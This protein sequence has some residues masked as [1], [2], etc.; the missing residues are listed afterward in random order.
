MLLGRK[1]STTARI[2]LLLFSVA[3]WLA[4]FSVV[5]TSGSWRVFAYVGPGLALLMVLLDRNLPA[6]LRPSLRGALFG[7]AIGVAMVLGT[8][9]GYWALSRTFPTIAESTVALF[10]L[11]NVPGFSA[12]HRALLIILIATSEELIFRGP[13]LGLAQDTSGRESPPWTT[14]LA[15][16]TGS[17]V[18]Y[19]LATITL[20]SPL[21]V[22]TAFCCG[23][24]WGVARVWARSLVAPIAAH[25]VWNLGVIVIWQVIPVD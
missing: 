9:A 5:R 16:I 23:M 21:L 12:L 8:H 15:H 18:V 14:S 13:L 25:V 20:H 1:L 10:G 11:L 4:A 3:V 24:I 6:L 2:T 17:A 7:C 22:I 19:A